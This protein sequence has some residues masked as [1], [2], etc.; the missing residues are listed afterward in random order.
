MVHHFLVSGA[1]DPT[2]WTDR[3]AFVDL[4]M[5]EEMRSVDVVDS[6]EALEADAAGFGIEV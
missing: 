1:V 6:I 3:L 2:D 5:A 4:Q